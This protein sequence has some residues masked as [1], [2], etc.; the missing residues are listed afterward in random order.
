MKISSLFFSI[1]S[2]IIGFTALCYAESALHSGNQ[3]LAALY[4]NVA[5]I[6]AV[7]LTMNVDRI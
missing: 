1:L 2:G 7:I 5:S 3:E 4:I 6:W